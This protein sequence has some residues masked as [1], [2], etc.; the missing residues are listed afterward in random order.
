MVKCPPD[1]DDGGDT[2]VRKESVE[3]RPQW[4]KERQWQQ[5]GGG[6]VR[7]DVHQTTMSPPYDAADA[8]D[9]ST[10]RLTAV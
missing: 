5:Q 6:T 2:L 4:L 7:H 9:P 8:D 1:D 3:S 10:T